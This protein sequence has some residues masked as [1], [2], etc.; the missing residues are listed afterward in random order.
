MTAEHGVGLGLLG[1]HRVA[2]HGGAGEGR[3][4]A[5]SV[6]IG[7]HDAA[8]S[9]AQRHLFGAERTDQGEKG[10]QRRLDGDHCAS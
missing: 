9:L 10:V 4:V 3:L 8:G 5:E 1:D 6:D 7:A 2:V